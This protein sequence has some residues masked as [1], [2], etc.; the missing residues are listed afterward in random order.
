M[1]HPLLIAA[2]L[3]V[4]DM[5]GAERAAE[6]IGAS[7]SALRH[8]LNP[9]DRANKLGL[10]DAATLS[11][12]SG[13]TRIAE[14]FAHE[15]GGVFIAMPQVPGASATGPTTME[16]AGKLATELGELLASAAAAV[17]DGDVKDSELREVMAKGVDMMAAWQ[18][19]MVHMGQLNEATRARLG[20]RAVA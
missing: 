2:R 7:E 9:N 20:A 10:L 6:H 8:Q 19:L 14:A 16:H 17:R 11:N 3:V 4:R 12:A 15:C 1:H 5:G 18:G 13:D